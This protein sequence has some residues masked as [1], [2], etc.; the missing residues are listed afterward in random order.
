MF[1]PASCSLLREP[2]IPKDAVLLYE[3]TLLQVQDSPDP[4]LL[5]AV[6]RL[7]R[8]NQKRE[9]G[10]FHFERGEYRWALRAYQQ[11]L[12]VL[13]LLE[14]G[15]PPAPLCSWPWRLCRRIPRP[16]PGPC[17]MEF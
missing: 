16:L 9:L 17:W 2:D 13:P 5:P 6:E 3:V 4:G 7:Q 8:G 1:L 10:N 15:K 12:Q 14:K 11:A